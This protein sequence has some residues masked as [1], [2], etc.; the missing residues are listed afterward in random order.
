MKKDEIDLVVDFKSFAL[1]FSTKLDQKMMKFSKFFTFDDD[2]TYNL[3]NITK[4][5]VRATHLKEKSQKQENNSKSDEFQR[6][7]NK[8]DVRKCNFKSLHE[9]RL[10]KRTSASSCKVQRIKHEFGKKIS[11]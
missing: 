7:S 10:R 5:D 11:I 4:S 8:R 3:H 2:N 9:I 6:I 1:F